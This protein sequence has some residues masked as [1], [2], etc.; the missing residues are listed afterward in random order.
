M[1]IERITLPNRYDIW[2]REACV[3]GWNCSINLKIHAEKLQNL[4]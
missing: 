2:N 4:C 1:L 3:S